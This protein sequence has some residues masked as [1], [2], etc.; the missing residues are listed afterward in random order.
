MESRTD[1]STP[2]ARDERG[3]TFLLE[4]EAA[5]P[6]GRLDSLAARQYSQASPPQDRPNVHSKDSS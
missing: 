6:G 4:V 5:L 1:C 3:G 2:E